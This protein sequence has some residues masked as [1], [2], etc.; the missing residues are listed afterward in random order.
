MLIS[1]IGD[2]ETSSQCGDGWMIELLLDRMFFLLFIRGDTTGMK[3]KMA[4]F[5]NL[6]KNL[7]ENSFTTS[8]WCRDQNFRKY[9]EIRKRHNIEPALNYSKFYNRDKCEAYYDGLL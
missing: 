6:N 7:H 2:K 4:N 9:F 5:N 8:F 1:T 3:K